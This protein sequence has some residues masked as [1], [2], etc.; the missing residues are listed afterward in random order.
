MTKYFLYARKSTESEDRQVLSIEAQITELREF[1]KKENLTIIA[2][3]TES[4]SAKEPG[5]PMFNEMLAK[6]EKGEADRIIAWHPDRLARNSVDGGRIIYLVDTGKIKDLK[7]P[8]FRFDNN[9]Y[10]KFILTIAFGQSKY[11]TDNLSENIKRGIRQKLRKGIWPQWAPLGYSND[12]KTKTIVIDEQK[13]PL[14]KKAF[15]LYATGNHSLKTL[16]DILYNEGLIGKKNKS[17]SVSNIEYFLKNPF[18]YG[19]I[20]YNGELYEGTHPPIITKQLFDKVQDILK[21]RHRA[22]RKKKYNFV[23]RGFIKCGECGAMITAETKKKKYV[24]YHC[25]KRKEKCYQP[26]NTTEQD[27]T[28]Q[29]V[30]GL[31]KIWLN[32]KT[33]NKILQ[34]FEKYRGK[35]NNNLSYQVQ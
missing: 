23:F 4:M 1:A 19:V 12:Y 14:I 3:F 9:A 20:R 21:Q 6:I 35:E 24:Y 32:D 27:L 28:N 2:E 18:Y 7:F 8:T 25:T 30:Y 26:F 10:G 29:I 17:L 22:T 33:I 15:E 11:Y 16:K 5:R 34:D 13:A 31:S